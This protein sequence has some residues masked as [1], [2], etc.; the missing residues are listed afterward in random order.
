MIRD[1]GENTGRENPRT[2][3]D[4][5][6]EGRELA[7]VGRDVT[8]DATAGG[9]FSEA[10]GSLIDSGTRR[11]DASVCVRAQERRRPTGN[12]WIVEWLGAPVVRPSGFMTQEVVEFSFLS[13]SK[14]IRNPGRVDSPCSAN[15]CRKLFF[16]F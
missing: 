5:L 14:K 11:R 6:R 4:R 15:G 10:A 7:D 9:I 12:G 13:T 1:E 3:R 8:A 2:G 16:S